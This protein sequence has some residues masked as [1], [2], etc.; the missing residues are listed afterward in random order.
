MSC[1]SFDRKYLVLFYSLP[2][3]RLELQLY[4]FPNDLLLQKCAINRDEHLFG[5]DSN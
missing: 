5:L 4:L 2:S 3:K 1:L